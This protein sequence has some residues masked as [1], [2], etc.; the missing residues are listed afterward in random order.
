[1]DLLAEVRRFR[2]RAQ[3]AELAVLT[4][5]ESPIRCISRRKASGR[6]EMLRSDASSLTDGYLA[7]YFSVSKSSIRLD[8]ALFLARWSREKGDVG[9]KNSSSPPL[10]L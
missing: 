7:L 1:M 9:C 3:I 6:E 5:G 10:G 2:L 8:T 4:E